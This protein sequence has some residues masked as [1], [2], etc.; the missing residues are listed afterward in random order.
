MS[1][2]LNRLQKNQEDE[3]TPD[4]DS[5]RISNVDYLVN[6]FEAKKP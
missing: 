5:N 1:E 6:E 4:N 3:W 2:S